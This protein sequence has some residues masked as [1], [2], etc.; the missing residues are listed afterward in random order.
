MTMESPAGR[1]AEG[2]VFYLLH[3]IK[4]A[5]AWPYAEKHLRWEYAPL[6]GIYQ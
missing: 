4:L 6:F 2:P 3:Q 5:V 1:D